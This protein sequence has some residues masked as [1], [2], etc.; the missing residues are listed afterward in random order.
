MPA[1]EMASAE[2]GVEAAALEVGVKAAAVDAGVGE[3]TQT[4]WLSANLVPR[5]GEASRGE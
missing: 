2:A 5:R 1:C 4:V 3:G